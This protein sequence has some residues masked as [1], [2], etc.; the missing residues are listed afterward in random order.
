VT[1]DADSD[2]RTRDTG[3]A[4]AEGMFPGCAPEVHAM[5]EGTPDGL[6]HA[7]ESGALHADSGLALAAVKGRI[8]G[9]A[10]NLTEAYRPQLAALDAV[11]A[12]CGKAAV[13]NAKRTSLFEIPAML[14][15]GKKDHGPEMRGPLNTASTMSE[16]LLLEYSEDMTGTNLGWGCLD[17]KKLDEVMQLHSA[18][19]EFAQRTPAM[20]RMLASNML[21]TIL[22]SL[23]QSASGKAT[24]GALGKTG[25]KVLFLSGHDT[26]I[27]AVAGALG[28]NWIVDG[29]RDDT[30]PGGALVFEL[31]RARTGG[32]YSVRVA[33]TAQTLD[34]MREAKPLTADNPPVRAQVFVPGCSGEDG[35][36][37]LDGFAAAVRR[38]IEPAQVAAQR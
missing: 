27:A 2:Q 1:I 22:R 30:P 28:L 20:A 34:Q 24:Q 15:A 12:G 23:E 4:I 16:N 26:N 33:Y 18:A 29:R 37:T 11:L 17:E 35:A 25:D 7:M 8:G 9:E 5:P 38:V 19:A 13:T 3:K 36:C 14:A 31:W 6:F 21:E 10:A 32:G